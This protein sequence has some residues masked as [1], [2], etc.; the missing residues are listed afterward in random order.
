MPRKHKHNRLPDTTKWQ[1]RET[2]VETLRAAFLKR[3]IAAEDRI[4]Q[5]VEYEKNLLIDSFDSGLGVED[6][7]RRE[8]REICPKRYSIRAGV[9]SDRFGKTAG[10]VDVVI[11]N[12]LWFPAI[13]AGATEESRRIHFPIE[14]VYAICEVKQTL[15]YKTLDAA[16]EKLVKC[17]RLHRPLALEGRLTENRD[18]ES[19]LIGLTNPLYSAIIATGL[20][21][22]TTLDDLAN[23][24]FDINNTLKRLEVVR[25]LCVLG[26]GTI[27]WGYKYSDTRRRSALFMRSEQDLS[28]PIF[29]VQHHVE[30]DAPSALYPFVTDLLLHLYHSILAAEDIAV[31]YG[32]GEYT[33]NFPDSPDVVLQPDEEWL[34]RQAKS[35]WAVNTED[36]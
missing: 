12:D 24:F 29:P 35:I 16:L 23:R 11:F 20:E 33:A 31:N 30:N 13:K 10:D 25:A 6:I 34:R 1:P 17:H 3:C 28:K 18:M 21:A 36:E 14:G 26:H 9:I 5:G 8:L 7:V 2:A 19:G 27:T 32:P 22:G 15:G 4:Q